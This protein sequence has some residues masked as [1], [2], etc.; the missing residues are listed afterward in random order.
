MLVSLIALFVAAI[1]PARAASALPNEHVEA[2]RSTWDS[3]SPPDSGWVDVTLPDDWTTRWPRFDGVVWYRITW[4][5]AKP[6]SSV[7]LFIEYLDMA[8][9][10][11]MNDAEIARDK[12]LVEPL[13]RMW[14]PPRY[15]SIPAQLLRDGKNVLLIRVS[16]LASYGPGLG[17]VHIGA[18][19]DMRAAF[20]NELAV[21]RDW[22]IST[23]AV[24]ASLSLFFLM[25]WLIRRKEIAY[26]WYSAQQFAWLN[27]NW[28]LI[29]TSTWPFATTDM[30]EVANT[31]SFLLFCG[32]YTMFVLRVCGQRWPRRE[33]LMWV[34][35]AIG[36]MA[37]FLTPHDLVG[38][39]RA[40]FTSTMTIYS[41][42]P[43][44]MLVYFGIRSARLD[45]YVL[46]A[47]GFINMAALVHDTLVFTGVL[48]SNIYY[49]QYSAVA[50][51]VGAAAVL[52]WN[53][54]RNL[55]RVE[56]F[57]TELQQS[58]EEARQ[59]LG[60]SLEREHLLQLAH[61]RLNERINL[62]HELHDGIGGM[63]V[64]NIAALEQAPDYVPSREA[65]N[66]LRSLREDLRLILDTSSARNHGENSLTK[67]L[68]PL[69]HRMT[70][71]FEAHDIEADWS[72]GN[73]DNIALTPPQNLDLLRILQ[74]GLTN[75]LK[76]SRAKHVRVKLSSDSQ[77]L[78][79]EIADDG[80]GMSADSEKE[81]GV[82]MHS[83]QARAA[84]LGA[85]LTIDSS[86][87]TTLVR[88]LVPHAV[89]E[90]EVFAQSS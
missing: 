18:P 39:V 11:Q 64:G 10:V 25:L 31:A 4:D 15:F 79:M 40:L 75:I 73:L 77:G 54:T 30:F 9:V 89:H 5:I 47:V 7:G 49:S 60:T 83:M 13:S 12:F 78:L 42:V 29:A 80:I 52:A 2:A 72:V 16:G 58:V 85:K 23:M 43:N 57:N 68:A 14:N 26:G 45:L 76:H 86:K 70:K 32:C 41:I 65:L 59:E 38:Q 62:M 19:D 53:F 88:L 3:A 46:A 20:E 67:L 50:V 55:R 1:A 35:L 87:G 51:A 27:G 36:S 84:R 28:N 90:H 17:P 33:V 8:G 63:L 22:Q 21:R 44:V 69:Q 34:L 74:E 56:S 66:M 61:V 24:I 6:Q 81:F 48:D 37:L 71:L 82:G